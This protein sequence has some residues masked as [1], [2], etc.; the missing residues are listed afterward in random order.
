MSGNHEAELG[1]LKLML[2]SRVYQTQFFILENN[3]GAYILPPNGQASE[4]MW[5][6][7]LGGAGPYVH[8]SC[9]KDHTVER[10]DDDQDS[11]YDSN[12]SFEYIELDGQ[13][14]VYECEGCSKKLAKYE[15]FIWKNRNH[16]REY[17]RIRID[18]EKNWADQEHLINVLKGITPVD[19]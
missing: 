10:E 5:D 3:M 12:D 19:G 9:G 16:I 4:M 11:W 15:N 2:I 1:I 7:G 6:A 18:Q 14:F 17:L 8:C 13:I